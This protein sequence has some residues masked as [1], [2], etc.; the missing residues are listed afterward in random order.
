MATLIRNSPLVNGS[1]YVVTPVLAPTGWGTSVYQVGDE[2]L[3]AAANTVVAGGWNNNATHSSIAS[4]P[5]VTVGGSTGG[6]I[7]SGD[8]FYRDG[9]AYTFRPISEMW[10][11]PFINTRVN[12]GGQVEKISK[13]D[14]RHT[15]S[16]YADRHPDLYASY[17]NGTLSGS[18][19]FGAAMYR[20]VYE[21]RDEIGSSVFN[22]TF[23]YNTPNYKGYTLSGGGSSSGYNF[24]N[25]P[26][27]SFNFNSSGGGSISGTGTSFGGLS[28]S[29]TGSSRSPFN[30]GW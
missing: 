10:D 21:D 30:F 7:Q 6:G 11:G 5:K 18:G 19:L 20:N 23:L 26:R 1:T 16:M 15:P 14:P 9:K 28:G 3:R 2:A 25:P 4:L 29:W 17:Q 24:T 8:T 22:K 12:M 27:V 13:S